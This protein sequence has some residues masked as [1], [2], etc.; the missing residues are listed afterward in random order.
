[1]CKQK[2]TRPNRQV[3]ERACTKRNQF[4][5]ECVG[6]VAMFFTLYVLMTYV[7]GHVFGVI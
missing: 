5:R 4:T 3:T 7:L 1:M 2:E 6:A